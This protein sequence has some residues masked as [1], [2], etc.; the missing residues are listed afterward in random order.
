MINTKRQSAGLSPYTAQN[1]DAAIAHLERVLSSE[2]AHSLFGQSYWRGRVVQMSTTRG[3][4]H[5]QRI[6][7]QRLLNLLENASQTSSRRSPVPDNA[8]AGRLHI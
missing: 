2:A 5:K 6:R 8:P 7:L 1:L 4:M 3:L